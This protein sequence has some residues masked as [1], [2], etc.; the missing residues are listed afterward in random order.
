[1]RRKTE[2][3]CIRNGMMIRAGNWNDSEPPTLTKLSPRMKRSECSKQNSLT[4]KKSL[5]KR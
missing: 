3:G 1:M 4:A 5:A 2:S